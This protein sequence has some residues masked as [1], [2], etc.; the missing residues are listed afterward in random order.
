M[1]LGAKNGVKIEDVENNKMKNMN[2]V[3]NMEKNI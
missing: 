1:K 3:A 2:E